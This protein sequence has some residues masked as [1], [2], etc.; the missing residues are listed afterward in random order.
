[1]PLVGPLENGS[2]LVPALVDG[3]GPYLFAI[4]PDANVSSVDEDVAHEAGLRT[5]QGPQMLDESDEQHPAFYA[6]I[7]QWQL[8]T[9]TVSN[10]PAL[11]AKSGTYDREGRRVHGVIGRDIIADS[12]VF[13]FDRDQGLVTLSTTKAFVPPAAATPLPYETLNNKDENVDVVPTPRRLVKASVDGKHETMHVSLG[14]VASTLRPRSLGGATKATV[15]LG[16]ITAE[17]APFAGYRDRRWDEQWLEGDLGLS[18]FKGY[19]V[20]ANWDGE[21]FYVWPRTE[22]SLATRLGRWQ[23]KTLTSC[24]HPG[25][26]TVELID[27]MAGKELTGPHPGAVISVARDASSSQLPLEVVIAVTGKPGL[28]WLL[29][30]LPAGADR[31]MTH[32]S[33]DYLGATLTIVDAS[34]FPRACPAAGGCIDKLAPP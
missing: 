14:E 27:P 24:E 7:L 10:K 21:T 32:V 11:L 9:L 34:P 16:P 12:L 1:V 19:D 13:Q 26:A 20:A 29:A 28:S 17:A 33:A 4:D 30:S 25:C 23:S 31:A 3:K 18:V 6:E 2:L 15:K 22:Q 5:G 8:G